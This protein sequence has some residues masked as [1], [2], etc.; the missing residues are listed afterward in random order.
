MRHT[1]STVFTAAMCLITAVTLGVAQQPSISSPSEPALAEADPE[2][3]LIRSYLAGHDL[4]PVK[5][6]FQLDV[7]GQAALKIQPAL[8]RLWSQETFQLALSLPISPIRISYEKNSLQT[9]AHVDPV[10]AFQLFGSMDATVPT[11]SG[12]LAQDL[13]AFGARTVFLEYWTKKGTH[14]LDEIRAQADRLGETGQYPFLAMSPI[15]RDLDR[16]DHLQA[17]LVF[18]EAVRHYGSGLQTEDTDREFWR[19]LDGMWDVIPR[20]LEKQ[21]LDK[22]VTHLTKEPEP[23]KDGPYVRKTY[24]DNGVVE[25]LSP[26]KQLLSSLLPRIREIDP[27]WA[28]Q[29]ITDNPDL[30]RAPGGTEKSHAVTVIYPNGTPATDVTSMQ[31]AALQRQKLAQIASLTTDNLNE[32]LS[33]RNTLTDGALRDQALAIIATD[34]STTNP[35]QARS[36]LDQAKK[37]FESVKTSPPEKLSL[38]VALAKAAGANHDQEL[39]VETL[40]RAFDLGEELFSEDEDVHTGRATYDL[41]GYDEMSDLTAV[42]MQFAPVPTLA[43]VDQL[44]NDELRAQLLISA[45]EVLADKQKA[46]PSRH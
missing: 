23:A 37:D 13:R 17:Q 42:G 7:L 20:N 9:M 21:A 41:V 43:H 25:S 11:E 15:I 38:L 36:L 14:A 12:R 26:A 4:D 33:V 29:L 45:A 34:L 30:T 27:K 44:S 2:Q 40:N 35:Q 28:D 1:L 22:L 6:A 10:L 39:L 46:A 32:A 19:L 16:Q 18:A 31:M 5:R 3:L 8:A 24:L